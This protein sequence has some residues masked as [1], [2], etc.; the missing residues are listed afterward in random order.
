[1]IALVASVKVKPDQ[2]EKF[3]AVI[4]DDS[5][6]SPRDEPGCARFDV[7]EDQSDANHFFFY[8]VYADEAAIQAHTRAP[9]YARWAAA[10]DVVLAEPPQ[11]TTCTVLF[12]RNYM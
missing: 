5:I 4:E 10:R 11:R 6:C 2:R 8:E 1:M 7:L 3:L 12:P 9:H